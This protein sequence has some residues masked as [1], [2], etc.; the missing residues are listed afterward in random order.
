MRLCG[1]EGIAAG[2]ER[3]PSFAGD[4]NPKAIATAHGTFA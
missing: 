4:R 1:F 3:G 2:L